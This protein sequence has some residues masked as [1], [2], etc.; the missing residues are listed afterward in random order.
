VKAAITKY[1]LEHKSAAMLEPATKKKKSKNVSQREGEGGAAGDGD[2]GDDAEEDGD[3]E[4]GDEEMVF[5]SADGN[6][7]SSAVVQSIVHTFNF[8]AGAAKG[9]DIDVREVATDWQGDVFKGAEAGEA[10]TTGMHIWATSLVFARWIVA[11][12]AEDPTVFGSKSLL[13]LGAGA[14]V[15][16]IVASMLVC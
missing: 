11:M 3:D 1:I 8:S 6:A 14:G 2:G 5:S 10:D 4:N 13:E 16:G 15:P 7:E 9:P 12:Q